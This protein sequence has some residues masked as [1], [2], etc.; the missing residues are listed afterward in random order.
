MSVGP[1]RKTADNCVRV[2]AGAIGFTGVDRAA[3]YEQGRGRSVAGAEREGDVLPNLRTVVLKRCGK[4][5]AGGA[6]RNRG[7]LA[8]QLDEATRTSCGLR[9][10]GAVRAA[11]TVQR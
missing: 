3:V 2:L 1:P 9:C 4:R 8:D 11:V 10:C 7:E 5:L 6:C